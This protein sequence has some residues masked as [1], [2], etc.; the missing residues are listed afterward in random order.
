M[1]F[2]RESTLTASACEPGSHI[3]KFCVTTTQWDISHAILYDIVQGNHRVPH[4]NGDAGMAPKQTSF[5][6][7]SKV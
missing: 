6:A 1:G 7:A 4:N 2:I 3:H 5:E